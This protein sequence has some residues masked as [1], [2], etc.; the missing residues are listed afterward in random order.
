M[1]ILPDWDGPLTGLKV[2]TTFR[3]AKIHGAQDGFIR[4]FTFGAVLL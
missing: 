2:F 3:N 1:D 4:V